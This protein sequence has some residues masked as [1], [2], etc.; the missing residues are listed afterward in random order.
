[1]AD[2]LY[3]KGI[4]I[5]EHILLSPDEGDEFALNPKIPSYQLTYMFFSSIYNPTGTIIN[6]E[7]SKIA[8]K[9]VKRWG[10]YYA[11]LDW[12]TKEFRVQGT[13]KMGIVHIQDAGWEGVHGWTNAYNIFD[14]ISDLKEANS[15]YVQGT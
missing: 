10:K 11:I 8:N 1:M 2:Y 12:V 13:R 9:G 5:G 6:Y 3:E 15:F 14:K 7:K 4:T